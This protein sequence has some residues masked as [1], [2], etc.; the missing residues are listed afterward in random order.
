MIEIFGLTFLFRD[1]VNDWINL[2]I[3]IL[4]I[5]SGIFVAIKCSNYYRCQNEM[6]S[7]P[8]SNSASEKP[9]ENLKETPMPPMSPKPLR[10]TSE[11]KGNEERMNASEGSEAAV[12][13]YKSTDRK[14][15]WNGR[16]TL[17][18][19][20]D[21]EDNKRLP[22]SGDESLVFYTN[23]FRG[24]SLLFPIVMLAPLFVTL[25]ICIYLLVKAVKFELCHIR[26]FGDEIPVLEGEED[27]EGGSGK[28][29]GLG[30]EK[31][32]GLGEPTGEWN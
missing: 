24:V 12:Q 9:L 7:Q 23:Q 22:G 17:T 14:L 11:Y 8:G 32:D 19:S 4:E 29:S 25:V 13:N 28:D 20:R 21:L 16:S 18:K 2:N 6:R 31:E 26:V 5:C 10:Q 3:Q 1:L 30:K 15:Y 27:V